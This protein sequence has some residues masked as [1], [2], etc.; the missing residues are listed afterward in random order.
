MVVADEQRAA[1]PLRWQVNG[2]ELAG[3][4]WGQAGDKPLLALHG[5]LDNAASFAF[6]APLLTGYQVVALDLTG[7][8]RSAWRSADASYQIWDDLPEI[9]GVLDAL[10]WDRFDLIGHSRGAI[11]STLLASAFPERIRHL[12]L[13]DAIVPG[14]VA[15]EDFPQQLRSSLLDKQRLRTTGNRVFPSIEDA[16]ASRVERGLPLPAA[17]VLVERNLTE[18]PGGVTWTTDPRLRGASAV[19]MGEAHIRAVLGRLDMPTLLLLAADASAR[20]QHLLEH[21]QPYIADLATD[22]VEGG[23]HFHM[24]ANVGKVG[25]TVNDFMSSAKASALT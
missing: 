15:D 6:L 21:V 8:G 19:K 1:V 25:K 18:C 13:L 17:R 14:A 23:H 24:E 10:G 16:V 7:H 20:T 22:S 3:L 12:V 9:L 11:I 5:W 2:L 4:C